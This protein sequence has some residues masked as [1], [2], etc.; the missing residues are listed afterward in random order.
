MGSPAF[1]VPAYPWGFPYA[2]SFPGHMAHSVPHTFGMAHTHAPGTVPASPAFAPF[3][4]APAAHGSWHPGV[5]AWHAMGHVSPEAPPEERS[6][7]EREAQAPSEGESERARLYGQAAAVGDQQPSAEGVRVEE[8]YAL[9][10]EGRDSNAGGSSSE[11]AGAEAAAAVADVAHAGDGLRHRH[12]HGSDAD[13]GR[14]DA[15]VQRA[16][17][18]VTEAL[19]ARIERN[20]ARPGLRGGRFPSL[21]RAVLA[22]GETITCMCVG[23]RATK[24]RRP[25]RRFRARGSPGRKEQARRAQQRHPATTL[26]CSGCGWTWA[27]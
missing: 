25:G 15:D 14:A 21:A 18:A 7:K 2:A 24:G 26:R 20:Q 4:A 10:R 11:T 12:V 27:C 23:C 13:A 16:V 19:M 8:A 22:I 6:G 3:A 9:E 1:V 17:Q 5:P